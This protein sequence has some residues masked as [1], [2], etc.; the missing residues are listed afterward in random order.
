MA[1]ETLNPRYTDAQPAGDTPVG[2]LWWA[3]R[4]SDGQRVLVGLLDRLPPDARDQL[5]ACIAAIRRVERAGSIHVARV[6]AQDQVDSGA[7]LLVW[8]PTPRM[9][10]REVLGRGPV[11][12]MRAV[13]IGRQIGLALDAAHREGEK[14]LDVAPHWIGLF[15]S[16]EHGEG[17]VVMG[18]GLHH[19]VPELPQGNAL[20]FGTPEYTAP[21]RCAGKPFDARADV[22]SLGVLLY[23]LI[24][25]RPPFTSR[26]AATT[27]KRHIYEKPLPLHL[28]RPTLDHIVEFEAIVF[29]ALAKDP[30]DRYESA[31]ELVAALEAFRADFA[32]D[33]EWSDAQAAIA[34]SLRGG[35]EPTAERVT[36]PAEPVAPGAPEGGEREAET[37][38]FVGIGVPETTEAGAQPE[39]GQAPG[40]A[41][42]GESSREQDTFIFGVGSAQP[43]AREG[44]A[45][46]DA[47]GAASAPGEGQTREMGTAVWDASEMRRVTT[48]ELDRPRGEAGG[49]AAAEREAEAT[50]AGAAQAADSGAAQARAAGE[51][52]EPEVAEERTPTEEIALDF[53]TRGESGADLPAVGLDH[54]VSS[55]HAG[56]RRFYAVMIAVAVVA[57]AGVALWI[58]NRG[59]SA[60]PEAKKPAPERAPVAVP[61][62]GRERTPAVDVGSVERRTRRTPSRGE[63]GRGT[64]TPKKPAPPPE[65]V[66]APRRGMEE[67]AAS[68]PGGPPTA[69]PVEPAAHPKPAEHPARQRGAAGTE[70]A[71]AVPAPAPAGGNA[72]ATGPAKPAETHPVRR[73]VEAH[74]AKTVAPKR[75]HAKPPRKVSSP[76]RAPKHGSP[77]ASPKQGGGKTAAGGPGEPKSAPPKSAPPKSA[78]LKKEPA[79]PKRVAASGQP[80]H[81]AGGGKAGAAAQSK[82]GAASAPAAPKAGAKAATTSKSP[83]SA[84]GATKAQGAAG[85]AGASGSQAASAAQQ[86]KKFVALGNKAL[87]KGKA[88]LALR[89]YRR[90][91]ELD[92]SNRL[93]DHFIQKAQKELA[94]GQH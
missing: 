66:A 64:A 14:H 79:S 93:I 29:K 91:K 73:T 84:K 6:A 23:E 51:T 48:A 44:A 8:A 35:S 88:K 62:I 41:A 72:G 59:G 68:S 77:A 17:V 16:R 94:G 11:D 40:T 2:G 19:A 56:N 50:G 76:S 89:Y 43:A 30:G 26:R 52:G 65:P 74:P 60:G 25:G 28:V 46:R 85:A 24:N 55:V 9:L 78:P 42:A 39:E 86:A 20:Y 31:A 36:E 90:A 45:Q 13:D 27:L 12:V 57:T 7:P 82:G 58:V 81:P 47:A 15:P 3:T 83:A 22:Y 4:R 32:P 92:P 10:L 70:R 75:H 21:E 49:A 71:V 67:R 54:D 37:Q 69:R 18:F 87:K 34:Q 38:I 33:F 1:D 5:D 63:A 61:A 80:P 53:F